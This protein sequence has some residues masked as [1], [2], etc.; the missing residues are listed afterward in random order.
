M[1]TFT[2]E[3][4]R[5][6]ERFHEILLEDIAKL[7]I[8]IRYQSYGYIDELKYNFTIEDFDNFLRGE[9]EVRT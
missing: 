1:K 4:Y 9:Y 6:M 5:E 8:L 3:Q 2:R 7:L